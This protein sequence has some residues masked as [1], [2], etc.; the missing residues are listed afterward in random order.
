MNQSPQSSSNE[1]KMAT[2]AAPITEPSPKQNTKPQPKPRRRIIL[3][4]LLALVIGIAAT[5]GGFWLQYTSARIFGFQP[6]QMAVAQFSTSKVVGD[7]GGMPV[8]IPSHFANFVEYDGDPGWGEKRKGPRP[9]RT[10]ASKLRS[11]GFYVRFP[12]M[13]GLSSPEMWNDKQSQKT[14]N[15]MWINVGLNAGERYKDEWGMDRLANAI[16]R[17]GYILK[18]EQYEQLPDPQHGLTVYAAAG[19]DPKTNKPYREDPYATDIFVHRDKAGRVDAYIRCSNRNVPAPPCRHNFSLEP[20]VK[21]KIDISYRRSLLPEWQQIQTSVTQ[22]ILTFKA[23]D[24]TS[25]AAPAAA[26]P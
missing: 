12:D 25:T 23:A 13:A 22:L 20:D 21:A 18:H 17:S 24:N 19:I 14:Y 8:T 5:V 2:P 26:R 16:G 11:F 1:E 6:P 10:H 15:T 7:L 9:E 3:W 4:L